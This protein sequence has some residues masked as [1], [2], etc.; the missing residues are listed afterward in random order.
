M[1]ASAFYFYWMVAS[2]SIL[3]GFVGAHLASF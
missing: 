3:G 1:R 2:S